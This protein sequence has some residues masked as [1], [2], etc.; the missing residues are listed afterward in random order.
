MKFLSV[1]TLGML[2]LTACSKSNNNAPQGP[3]LIFKFHFD[4]TQARLGN[5]GNPVAVAAGNAAQHPVFRSMSSHYLELAPAAT[6]LLGKGAVLYKAPETT[7]GGENAIDFAQSH[8]V[9][10][11]EVFFAI[12]LSQVQAG[13]YEWLRLSLAYQ[14]YDVKYRVDTVISNIPFSGTFTGTIASF[15]GFNTYLQ[16]YKV[17]DQQVTVNGNRKQGYWA[18][19]TAAALQGGAGKVVSGQAPAGATTVVNPLFATSPVPQGSC[20]VTGQFA[21]GKL[22][23]TGKEQSDIVVTVSLSVNNSFEW[24]DD[25]GNGLWEPLR[26]EKVV[27]MGIRG[28]IPKLSN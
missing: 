23:I 20:V 10:E 4:S 22:Q 6:T 18:F 27:D 1:I 8:A 5:T 25:N 16:Q 19:E 14:N 17:K 24:V 2:L 13:T 7:A 26:G 28:M 11:G 21:P 12:P 9:G 15:I 3:Q